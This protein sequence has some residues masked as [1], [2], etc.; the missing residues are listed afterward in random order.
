MIGVFPHILLDFVCIFCCI[1]CLGVFVS[2]IVYFV[3]LSICHIV[4]PFDPDASICP[5]P[6]SLPPWLSLVFLSSPVLSLPSLSLIP[7]P[8]S[9]P[10]PLSLYLSPPFSFFS[11]LSLSHSSPISLSF[12][13]IHT[14]HLVMSLPPLSYNPKEKRNILINIKSTQRLMESHFCNEYYSG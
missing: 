11:P 3:S 13:L 9:L 8:F 5:V 14:T 6:L 7:P 2:P 12:P 10:T 4:L 1:R